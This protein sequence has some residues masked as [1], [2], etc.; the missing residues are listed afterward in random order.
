MCLDVDIEYLEK[1]KKSKG[2]VQVKLMQLTR[3]S[4]ANKIKQIYG[5]IG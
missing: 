4:V 2:D 5:L 1:S 3:D